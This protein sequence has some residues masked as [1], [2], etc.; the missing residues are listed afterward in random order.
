MNTYSVR[1][2]GA[3]NNR[4]GPYCVDVTENFE[5]IL[6]TL[7]IVKKVVGKNGEAMRAPTHRFKPV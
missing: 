2:N 1:H 6:K 4:H 3:T 5:S 7:S